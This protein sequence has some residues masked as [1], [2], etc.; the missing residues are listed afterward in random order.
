MVDRAV[1]ERARLPGQP[2]VR[3]GPRRQHGGRLRRG[4]ARAPTTA[5]SPRWPS[6]RPG[7]ATRLGTRLLHALAV[8]RHRAGRQEPHPRGAGEQRRGPGALPGL[9]LRAGRDPQGLLRRDQGGRHHHV[10][11]RRRQPGVRRAA[12]RPRGGGPRHAPSTRSSTDDRRDI[13]RGRILGIETSCDETAAAIVEAGTSVLSSVVSSQV[14]L[15]ARY[16]GVVPEIASRAHVDLIVPVVA[17]AFVEAGLSDRPGRR[18]GLRDRR[19]RRHLRARPRGRAAR[20]RVG[21]QGPR[22]GLGRALHRRQPPRGPPLRHP[23]RG[24]RPRA[25]ARRPARVRR[26]HADR[27]DGGPRAVPGARLDDRRRGRGGLRQGRS[28]PRP[29]LPGRAGDRPARPSRAIPRPSGSRAR[30]PGTAPTTSPSAASRRR[31]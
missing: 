16:G 20:G 29:R 10:G 14:D 9:R 28:L 24:A 25:A 17:Q 11:Q 4:D 12:R 27:A 26:A 22:A 7:T 30:W 19:R 3:R 5:T 2:R 31:S 8:G 1:H 18:R 15:H 13:G 6:T 23:P 21:R